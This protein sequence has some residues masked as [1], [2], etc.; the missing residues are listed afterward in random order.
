MKRAIPALV[1]L[2]GVV[3][4][5]V[6]AQVAAA[7]EIET[8]RALGVVEGTN[9]VVALPAAGTN[10]GLASAAAADPE[11][12]ARARQSRIARF[13]DDTDVRANIR[14]LDLDLVEGLTFG[15]RYQYQ[16][17]QSQLRPHYYTRVDRYVMG[18]DINPG[19][20][21]DGLTPLS[22]GI[23]QE[24][25]ILFMQQF[26]SGT[27]ARKPGN[28]YA[29]ARLPVNTAKA[30][31]LKP[32]DYV[33]FNAR[34]NALLGVEQVFTNVPGLDVAAG[35][36]FVVRGDFQVHVFRLDASRLRLKLVALRSDAKNLQ[37]RIGLRAP[38]IFGSSTVDRAFVRMARLEEW[39]RAQVSSSNADLFMVDYVLNLADERTAGV[40]D[41][42]FSSVKGVRT[43]RIANPVTRKEEL[44]ARLT[45][46]VAALEELALDR[47]E[48]AK[49]DPM[50]RAVN[51][52]F[53]GANSSYTTASAF[54]LGVIVV[55]LKRDERYRR[56]FLSRI[57][58]DPRTGEEVAEHYL[59]PTWNLQSESDGLITKP[60]WGAEET[61]R[62]AN[63][64]FTATGDG[65]PLDFKNITFTRRQIDSR[66]SGS[67]YRDA[68]QRILSLLS[69][70]G[71]ESFYR[72]VTD[73]GWM[74]PS[75]VR[76]AQLDL[77][78]FF[79]A[80]ALTHLF[81]AGWGRKDRLIDAMIRYLISQDA[82][83]TRRNQEMLELVS[84][85]GKATPG[86]DAAKG[87]LA[88][89]MKIKLALQDEVS[90]RHGAESLEL[91]AMFEAMLAPGTTGT[92]TENSVK[93]VEALIGLRDSPLFR[94]VGPGFIVYLLRSSNLDVDRVL[95]VRF[96][97]SAPGLPDV[98]VTSGVKADRELYDVVEF[99]E[100]MLNGN[101]TDM[102][103][104]GPRNSN[105]TR[106]NYEK[107]L[108]RVVV[109]SN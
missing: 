91:C 19:T 70:S 36:S 54:R 39:F 48:L 47:G 34:L 99:L 51:R 43:Y 44:A 104:A 52:L 90:E 29:P 24:T 38:E 78:Y 10:G 50:S 82:D 23:G 109:A 73:T 31:A 59:V 72:Q 26:E 15:A 22:F 84:E 13:L 30:L 16:V 3:V 33:R 6:I 1:C 58:V 17:E 80:E 46:N 81:A 7:P 79:H 103:L 55:R 68:R 12:V 42:L 98:R 4:S 25:E 62:S 93:R 65:V 8:G 107:L 18:A 9:V 64:L 92:L 97:M 95:Y 88:R 32:G 85:A 49:P 21:I 2:A 35:G 83:W 67:E 108:E 89:A 86:S 20:L 45:S 28:G 77:E 14:L 74:N 37:A 61:F 76:S 66:V 57:N 105:T 96:T 94:K 5:R 53:K 100:A 87:L 63:A 102:R 56:N 69:E 75:Q 41:E 106:V 71:R 11:I 40:Y 27:E 101:E 60:L